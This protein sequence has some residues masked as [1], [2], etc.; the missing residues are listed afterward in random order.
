[1]VEDKA[2]LCISVDQ[3]K[4]LIFIGDVGYIK[5]MKPDGSRIESLLTSKDYAVV[6]IALYTQRH[7]IFASTRSKII[8]VTY[9]GQ[10]EKEVYSGTL[11]NAVTIDHDDNVLYYSDFNEIFQK[12]LKHNTS[13]VI[14]ISRNPK[15]MLYYGRNI[16]ISHSGSSN[17]I[18]LLKDKVLNEHFLTLDF[19]EEI[20]RGVFICV[21]P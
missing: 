21:I 1:M 11:V 10:D 13:K 19:K 16:F 2:P 20:T 17:I 3:E 9:K 8:S 5:R 4:Q 18:G 14:K 7:I 6:Q 15:R 12:S